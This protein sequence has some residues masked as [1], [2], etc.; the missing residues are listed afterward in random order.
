MSE[1]ELKT[2]HGYDFFEV[3]SALQKSIRRGIEEKAMYWAVELYES[4]YANYV[5]K[6]LIVMASEDV[7]LGSPNVI[8]QLQSLKWSYDFLASKKDKSLPERLPFTQAVLLMVHCNKSRYVDHAIT[9]Y[10]DMVN[11]KGMAMD[12]WVYDGHTRR[13]KAMG[14]GLQFFYEES[15]KINNARKLPNEEALEK[16]AW[17]IDKVSGIHREDGTSLSVDEQPK[18][19]IQG[20]LF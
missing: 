5:W 15:A 10:W 6:R 7:G 8:C 3:A 14:R 2:K 12:D 13:G 9:V 19:G 16:Q 17:V 4:N 11:T 20:E 1:F 18:G